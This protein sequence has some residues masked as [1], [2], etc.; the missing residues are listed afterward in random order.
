MTISISLKLAFLNY[1]AKI[2]RIPMNS[3]C[4][5][6]KKKPIVR[7]AIDA[8]LFSLLCLILHVLA[9]L[10]VLDVKLPSRLSF[11]SGSSSSTSTANERKI[12]KIRGKGLSI[13][14]QSRRTK[15]QN[16]MSSR[17]NSLSKRA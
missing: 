14:R 11:I 10:K 6:V 1:I 2:Q 17:S 13:G 5:L 15:L 9:T 8:C 4:F 3:L 7:M 16:S 12:N